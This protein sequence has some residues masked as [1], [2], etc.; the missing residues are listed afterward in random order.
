MYG[1]GGTA[2]AALILAGLWQWSAARLKD[3]KSERE[4]EVAAIKV[5]SESAISDGA[6]AEARAV[7]AEQALVDERQVG[8]ARLE[9]S[10]MIGDQLFSWAME[11]G[12]RR[13]PPLDGRE[14][15]LKRLERYFEDFLIRTSDIDALREERA[16]VRLQLAEISLAAG[17]AAGATSRLAEV[18]KASS[19]LSVDADLKMRMATNSLLLALLRQ[20]QSDPATGEAFAN[21]RKKFAD[22]PKAEVDVVRMDQLLAILDFHEAKLLA[23]N[24]EDA[25]ALEQLMRATQTLNRISDQRPDAVILRSELAACYLASA[26]I[27]EGMGSLGDAREVRRLAAEELRAIL[28]EKPNDPVLRLELAGCYGTMAESAVLSGDVAGAEPLLREAL[29]LLDQLLIEQPDH[30]EAIARKAAQLGLRAGILRDL[31]KAEE[32]IKDFDEGIRMLEGVRAS[33]TADGMISYRLALL[34]WQKGRMLGTAGERDQEI[35]L[36]RKA[37]DLLEQLA[38]LPLAGELRPE[39]LQRSSAYLLGDLGHALQLAGKNED[40]REVFGEALA[41]WERLVAYRP[42][43]EEY[44]EGLEWC[45]QRL[46]SL[47]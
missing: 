27:L 43:S 9:A 15:R 36:I 22:V 16:R 46:E 47:K 8:V 34:W 3:E 40:A 23:A 13:L 10:R 2:A 18:L 45:R 20:S 38:A 5:A 39:Q 24:G 19:D 41:I 32:A 29:A 4:R 30:L 11:K 26:T 12:H 21:A 35:V 6:T 37:D 14:L 31:G 1:L 33:S 17:D 25:K 44:N 28:K 7:K 42:R